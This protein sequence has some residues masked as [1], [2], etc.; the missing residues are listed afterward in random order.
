M[1]ADVEVLV[2]QRDDVVVR[3][4]L[5]EEGPPQSAPGAGHDEPHGATSGG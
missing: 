3:R 4:D 5:V 2:R 1:G